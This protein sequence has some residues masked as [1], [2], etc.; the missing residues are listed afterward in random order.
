MANLLSLPFDIHI[1]IV[2]NLDLQTCLAYAQVAPVCHDAVYYIFAHCTELDFSSL[3]VDNHYF[4]PVPDSL[5]MN[6]LYSH[7]RVTTL[8]NFCL[9][10]SFTAF[11]ELSD[12][13]NLYWSL[14]F[15]PEYD[16]SV[17]NSDTICG[18]YVGHIQGQLQS[19]YYIGQYY[20]AQNPQGNILQQILT[21]LQDDEYGLQIANESDYS[22]PLLS[23]T[24]NWSIIDLDAPYNRCTM[25]DLQIDFP[26]SFC[27]QCTFIKDFLDSIN[28]N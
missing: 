6:I 23:D 19:I 18:R 13:F 16:P 25:C 28:N 1:L 21:P 2:R 27:S 17:H 26:L 22:V 20:G 12:Y 15:I 10:I 14:T 7:T 5:F 9:P 8:R 3:L 4:Y 11:N 24:F